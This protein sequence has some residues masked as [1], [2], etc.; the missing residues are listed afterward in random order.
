MQLNKV[1]SANVL[2]M[3]ARVTPEQRFSAAFT[4]IQSP[5]FTKIA[6]IMDHSVPETVGFGRFKGRD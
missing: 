2:A 6:R 5:I 4:R 1:E 3:A